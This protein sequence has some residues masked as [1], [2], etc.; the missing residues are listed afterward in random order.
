MNAVKIG[1]GVIPRVL[2]VAIGVAL[3]VGLKVAILDSSVPM[4]LRESVGTRFSLGFLSGALLGF[5]LGGICGLEAIERYGR[6]GRV[7]GGLVAGAGAGLGLALVVRVRPGAEL[8][9]M[10]GGAV[11]GAAIGALA[12]RRT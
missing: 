12:R 4:L 2:L 5:V 9:W 7:I 6:F 8:W 1:S 10:V 11:L 3:L